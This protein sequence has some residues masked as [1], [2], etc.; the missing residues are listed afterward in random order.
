LLQDGRKTLL[1]GLGNPLSGDDVFGS[2]VLGQLQSSKT[3]LP[4]GITLID[5]HSDLLN[6]IEDFAK[7]DGILLIDAILDPESKL[8]EPGKIVVL[9]E[10]KLQSLPEASQS[11]HQIS[12]LLAVK[13]FR[14]LHPEAR[15]QFTLI[16][17][18]IDQLKSEPC[19][20]TTDRITEATAIIKKIV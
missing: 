2:R 5:A 10:E 13:L 7:Y 20:A 1:L 12:P 3:A 9:Q 4:P 14:T 16:G 6:H 8:G 17:L 19:Y 11:V 15:T 18:I